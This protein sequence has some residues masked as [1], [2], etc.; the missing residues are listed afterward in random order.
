MS[1]TSRQTFNFGSDF[2]DLIL[3]CLVKQHEQFSFLITNLASSHFTGLTATVVADSLLSY[4]GQYSKIPSMPVLEELAKS[5][6]HKIGSNES[7]V[8]EYVKKLEDIDTSDWTFVKD[9]LQTFIQEREVLGVLRKAIVS[10]QEGNPMDYV[11]EF[12]KA[13]NVCRDMSELGLLFDP[14]DG[15]SV[16]R[17]V[18]A[19]NYGIRCGYP[20]IDQIFPMGFA[21]GWLVVP[22]APPKSCKCLGKGT[23]IRMFDGSVKKVEDLVVGD[24]LMGD[25]FTPRKV[26][27]C[28]S[29]RGPLYR[30]DVHTRL[31]FICN[32]AHI[33]CLKSPQGKVI[34]MRADEYEAKKPSFR[35]TWRCY[36]VEPV[37]SVRRS[38]GR[39]WTRIKPIGTG[40]YYGFEIDGNRRFM[41]SDYVVTH[42]TTMCL[43][44]AFN[45]ISPAVDEDVIYN[46]CEI[47]QE[48][49]FMRQL[50]RFL[51]L[52]IASIYSNPE[53]FI[54]V[55][56]NA[57]AKAN[58]RSKLLFKGWPAGSATISDLRA[59]GS[60]LKKEGLEAKAM[61]IDYAETVKATK[62]TGEALDRRMQADI[63]TA[64]RAMG[65]DLNLAVFMPDRCNRETVSMAVPNM[66]SFQGAFQKGGIVDVAFGICMTEAEKLHNIFRLF[67][68][69]NRHG[70][71]MQYFRG[72]LDLETYRMEINEEIDY[73]PEEK[74][75]QGR[76]ERRR[77]RGEA[78]LPKELQE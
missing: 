36:S 48:L 67:V 26:L 70:P 2:Q 16:V 40:T 55:M 33:L 76:S 68:F 22:L 25:D 54:R 38:D 44:F 15:E 57:F 77:S 8:T 58:F 59:H 32:D 20:L 74:D 6:M 9:K 17:K 53:Q 50:C 69:L 1:S 41:L 62:P 27:K 23:L 34:E 75:E 11:G 52:P 66:T 24:L 49:A 21:P 10:L 64:A 31:S 12:T 71:S 43:N 47:S 13:L 42:N 60:I 35:K 19:S 7:E 78:A 51:R 18:T 37:G 14:T 73:I 72:S 4:F 65:S 3:A 29:G 45:M 30:V 39:H 56:R 63:Y 61:F 28:G 46:T 5:K